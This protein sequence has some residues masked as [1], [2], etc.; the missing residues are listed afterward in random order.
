[1]LSITTELS[2]EAAHKIPD[3][4]GPCGNLHGHS[5]KVQVTAARKRS[6]GIW[7][8]DGMVVDFK[9]LKRAVKSVIA[10]F[11]HSYINDIIDNPT[12]EKIVMYIAES[13]WTVFERQYTECEIVKI[14]L[15][16]TEKN[17]VEWTKYD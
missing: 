11:D 15:W 16:E 5:Y 17:F 4:E 6:N 14:K 3:Y 8:N 2:F 10:P 9:E 1:M 12:A 7:G 13:L